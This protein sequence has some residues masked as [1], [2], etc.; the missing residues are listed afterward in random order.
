MR[1]S[2]I[3]VCRTDRLGDV[4]LTLPSIQKLQKSIPNCEIF[5]LCQEE[6]HSLLD[7]LWKA[8]NIQPLLWKKQTVLKWTQDFRSHHLDAVLFLL[9]EIS[10]TTASFLARIPV[11]MGPWSHP[12]SWILNPQGY[13]QHRSRAEQTEAEYNLEM[14]DKLCEQWGYSPTP[15]TPIRLPLKDAWVKEAQAELKKLGI[16][17]QPYAVVHPGMGGSARNLSIQEYIRLLQWVESSLHLQTVLTEGPSPIDKRLVSKIKTEVPS[18][19]VFQSES[20][21]KLAGLFSGAR[22]VC[23]PSTGPLHLAHY[24]GAPTV[25]FFSPVRSQHPSRWRPFGGEG[26]VTLVVPDVS[27]PA[28]RE[29]L[30]TRCERFD[31]MEKMAWENLILKA[32]SALRI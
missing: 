21:S 20:L 3:L 26:P 13:Y 16:E 5:F 7:P 32:G 6:I 10:L 14:V 30:G 18:V 19:R 4:L 12:L 8:W 1:P 9:P 29:C 25:A 23:A 11:R 22:F 28:K 31:C 2:R 27:C 17:E 24:V 15:P